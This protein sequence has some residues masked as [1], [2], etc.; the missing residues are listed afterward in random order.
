MLRYLLADSGFAVFPFGYTLL[1]SVDN[2]RHKDSPSLSLSH[3]MQASP[4]SQFAGL[5]T[6]NTQKSPFEITAIYDIA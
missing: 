5:Y 6:K 4:F 2:F 1:K 3:F